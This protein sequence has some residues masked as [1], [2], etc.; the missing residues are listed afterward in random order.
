M[1]VGRCVANVVGRHESRL[2][3]GL[4]QRR[5]S[6]TKTASDNRSPKTMPRFPEPDVGVSA[7]SRRHI[8]GNSKLRLQARRASALVP[9]ALSL[10]P[11]R[12]KKTAREE[13]TVYIH[14]GMSRAYASNVS[15]AAA[16]SAM[17]SQSRFTCFPE[18]RCTDAT[19]FLRSSCRS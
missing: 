17:I 4:A 13:A 14:T 19:A 12:K 10:P 5:C 9:P 3:R 15:N 2:D 7:A 11:L 16:R 8:S 6:Q 1:D 18:V